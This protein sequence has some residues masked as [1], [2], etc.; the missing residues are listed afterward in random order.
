MMAATFMAAVLL[1]EE[2]CPVNVVKYFLRIM[3][4]DLV[5]FRKVRFCS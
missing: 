4:H 2:P 1:A 5:V 3:V